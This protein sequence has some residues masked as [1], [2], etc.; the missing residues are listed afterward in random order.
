MSKE[1]E[2]CPFCGETDLNKVKR[3]H[4]V[5][6]LYWIECKSCACTRVMSFESMDD[7]IRRWNTRPAEDAL[8]AENERLKKLISEL[9]EIV[10][11]Y[12]DRHSLSGCKDSIYF[13]SR[14]EEY[15]SK[16]RLDEIERKK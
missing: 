9:E 8:K 7:A 3:L 14:I 12:A 4:L 11:E 13:M 5:G 6:W 2:S 10:R 15:F 1:L 16:E